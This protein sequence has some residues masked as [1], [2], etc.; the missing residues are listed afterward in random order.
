MAAASR[1][2][3][4]WGLLAPMPAPILVELARA[5]EREGR[6]GLFAPQV[7]GPPFLPLAAAAAVTERIQLATGIAIAS[8]RSPFE[9][10]MA[11]IDM[12]RISGSRFVLGLGASVLSWSRGVFG[13]PEHKPLRHLRET[14]AAVRHIVAG[15][16][17]GLEPFEGEYYRADFRELQPTAPPPREHIPIWIAGMRGPAIRLA[18]EV[19]EGVM[20]HPIA[21]TEAAWE[22]LR[23]DF[24]AGLARGGRRRP[25]VELHLWPWVMANPDEAQAIDEARPTVAF[26]AGIGQYEPFFAVHG[27]GDVA[28]RLQEGV[29]RRR[30]QDYAHL[31]PDD[32][33]RSLV[34]CGEPAK[35]R[36]QVERLW[37]VA[38]SMCPVAPFLGLA[39]ERVAFAQGMIAQTFRGDG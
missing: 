6:V 31:V 23:P 33:V 18:A 22:K 24:E 4:L 27:F 34:F 35:V 16:H 10:A 21:S 7:Y 17:R 29:R 5:A 28:R 15:A 2:R 36:E 11:A 1:E 19:A 32:M 9:T 14:V 12:D 30:F 39:P 20:V 8:A 25:D 38:D 26:Y 37:S 13:A 3:R